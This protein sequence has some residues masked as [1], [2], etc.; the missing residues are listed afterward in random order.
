MRCQTVWD[1]VSMH[2]LQCGVKPCSVTR[3]TSKP[4]DIPAGF[5]PDFG[6]DEGDAMRAA[7][8]D[9]S[10][11]ADCCRCKWCTR[12]CDSISVGVRCE[13]PAGHAEIWHRCDAADGSGTEEWRR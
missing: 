13:L 11:H 10:T 3:M 5:P 9:T 8:R 4:K 2:G 12:Q 1:L 7:G 6:T